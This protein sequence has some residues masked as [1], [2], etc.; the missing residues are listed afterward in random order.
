MI[1]RY[2]IRRQI[3]LWLIVGLLIF[4][5]FGTVGTY[6]ANK[7]KFYSV[8]VAPEG[9]ASYY[10][11]PVCEYAKIKK[12]KIIIKGSIEKTNRLNGETIK[13][14]KYKKR[15]FKLKKGYKL[16]YTDATSEHKVTKKQ[17]N[18]LNAGFGFSMK[19]NKNG[20]VVKIMGVP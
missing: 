9:R 5:Y 13:I 20:E 2:S 11:Y 17:F 15:T 1:K 10:D 8:F 6:A 3:W 14:L 12:G 16:T 19:V 4:I 7:V 18:S